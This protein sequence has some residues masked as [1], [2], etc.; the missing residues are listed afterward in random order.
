MA[1]AVEGL[2][3]VELLGG[4][5]KQAALLLGAAAGL[6]GSTVAGDPHVTGVRAAAV[7]QIGEVAFE[8][9]YRRGAELGREE[10]LAMVGAGG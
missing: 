1:A 2:A 9:A 8:S 3:G 4:D 10:I 5:P 6:R 7:A